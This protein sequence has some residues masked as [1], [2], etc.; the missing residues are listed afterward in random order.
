MEVTF[1]ANFSKNRRASSFGKPSTFAYYLNGSHDIDVDLFLSCQ[2]DFECAVT[3]KNK[4]KPG[5][6]G[7]F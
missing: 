7:S 4:I 3:E 1:F 5:F 6:S 2:H